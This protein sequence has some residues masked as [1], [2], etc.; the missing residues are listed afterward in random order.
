MWKMINPCDTC[1]TKNAT[2]S[3]GN[4]HTCPRFRSWFTENWRQ[5]RIKFGADPPP[6]HRYKGNALM[7]R[8]YQE[9]EFYEDS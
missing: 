9:G 2:G 4:Y 1:R 8:V 6:P 5:I 3:C 7:W